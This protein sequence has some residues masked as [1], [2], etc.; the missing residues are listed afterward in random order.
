MSIRLSRQRRLFASVVPWLLPLGLLG[1]VVL[2][3]VFSPVGYVLAGVWGL[4]LFP[5]GAAY[6]H[7]RARTSGARNDGSRFGADDMDYWR[8]KLL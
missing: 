8:T 2:I 3:S 1:T 7:A 6:I 5:Y 4:V